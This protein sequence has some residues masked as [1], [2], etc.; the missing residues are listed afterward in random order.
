MSIDYYKYERHRGLEYTAKEAITS[1]FICCKTQEIKDKEILLDESEIRLFEKLNITN[2]F[3]L[4][5]QVGV[6]KNILLGKIKQLLS[7]STSSAIHTSKIQS[8]KDL[9]QKYKE[10]EDMDGIQTSLYKEVDLITGLRALQ[11]KPLIDEKVDINL[12]QQFKFKED[13]LMTYFISHSK[14][15]AMLLDKFTVVVPKIYNGVIEKRRRSLSQEEIEE[16]ERMEKEHMLKMKSME[17][18]GKREDINEVKED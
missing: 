9:M 5:V 1:F 14:N 15:M 6:I 7:Y 12:I 4:S 18:I 11:I 2:I 13:N 10:H 8:I 17:N 3:K 16:K